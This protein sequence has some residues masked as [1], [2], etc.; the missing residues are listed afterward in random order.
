MLNAVTTEELMQDALR[1]VQTMTPR[2]KEN[3]RWY[4]DLE[5]RAYLATRKTWP[6]EFAG[7]VAIF[8]EWILRSKERNI[9]ALKKNSHLLPNAADQFVQQVKHADQT[10]MV[11]TIR[12]D[13]THDGERVIGAQG[14]MPEELFARINAAIED[15]VVAY[16]AEIDGTPKGK[17]LALA[18]TRVH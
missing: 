10:G 11:F 7:L 6:L 15:V 16:V 1:T 2:E 14:W 9:M 17:P 13:E 4:L 8:K 12:L 18:S 5:M 3:V